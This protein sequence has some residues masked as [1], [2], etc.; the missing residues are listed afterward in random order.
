MCVVSAFQLNHVF[1][2]QS[3]PEQPRCWIKILRLHCAELSTLKGQRRSLDPLKL[4][5][6]EVSKYP[7]WVLGPKLGPLQGQQVLLTDEPLMEYSGLKY[8]GCTVLHCMS[9]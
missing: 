6:Q 4:K 9:Y 7:T 1:E 3:S 2:C 8:S 5:L